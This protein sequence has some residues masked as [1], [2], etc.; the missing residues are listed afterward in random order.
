MEMATRRKTRRTLGL[1]GGAIV[2]L[3]LAYLAALAVTGSDR[4]SLLDFLFNVDTLRP[5]LVFHDAFLSDLYPASGW[6]HGVAPCYFPDYALLWTLF[7]LGV[8]FRI[9]TLLLPLLFAIV[10]VGGWIFVCD[11]IYA[12]SWRRRAAVIFLHAVPFLLVAGGSFE[13]FSPSFLPVFHYGTWIVLP[14]ILGFWLRAL[15]SGASSRQWIHLAGGG[16]LLALTVASDLIIGVWLVGPAIFS[17]L[18]MIWR[19]CRERAPLWNF[20]LRFI[21]AIVVSV[22]A[23][24]ILA[25]VPDNMPNRNTSEFLSPNLELAAVTLSG[26]ISQL[27]AAIPRAPVTALLW[28]VF[29]AI[30]LWRFAVALVPQISRQERLDA[31]I[32]VA[33]VPVHRFVALFVPLSAVSGIVGQSLGGLAIFWDVDIGLELR[34]S[35]PLFCFPLFIG[36][37]LLPMAFAG[38][39]AQIRDWDGCGWCLRGTICYWSIGF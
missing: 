16:V 36:W 4:T 21:L 32:G 7:A 28:A 27:V 6:R 31:L 8:D 25:A 17:F 38:S 34:Y 1:V 30:A 3:V 20:F 15:S 5:W 2:T 39:A 23:G 14:W 35:L 18:L 10:S 12:K 33:P 26:I 13:P 11:A 9:A 24:L 19:Q 29:S 37:A 22:A